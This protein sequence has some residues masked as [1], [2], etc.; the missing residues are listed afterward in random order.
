MTIPEAAERLGLTPVKAYLL[1]KL[2]LGKDSAYVTDAEMRILAEKLGLDVTEPDGSR[3]EDWL[4]PESDP[5]PKRRITRY[6][7]SRLHRQ[8]RWWPNNCI[9]D[10]AIRHGV[11][12][13][14]KGI[15]RDAR[16]ALIRA[17]WLKLQP[18]R[19]KVTEAGVGLNP[20]LRD[21]IISFVSTGTP[22]DATLASWLATP[23]NA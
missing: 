9:S 17:G 19:H 20:E 22:T 18:V 2:H 7:V 11:P 15:V 4:N 14:E 3:P 13:H 12:E 8:H 5:N 23:A 6:L 1:L 10:S 21:A 16:D